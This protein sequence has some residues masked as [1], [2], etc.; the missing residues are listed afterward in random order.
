MSVVFSDYNK[1]FATF[2]RGCDLRVEAGDQY[3]EALGHS[4]HDNCFTCA[5]SN[6]VILVIVVLN[7]EIDQKTRHLTCLIINHLCKYVKRVQWP[8]YLRFKHPHEPV[9]LNSLL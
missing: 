8:S 3:I 4:W 2:C 9:T 5:V 7:L 6:C 1:I